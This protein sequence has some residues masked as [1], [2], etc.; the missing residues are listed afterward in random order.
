[1][2]LN[3]AQLVVERARLRPASPAIIT[4]NQVIT[5]GRLGVSIGV[6]ASHLREQGVTPGQ[7]VGISMGQNPLHVI[8]LL[9]LA[10]I[11]AVSLPLHIA[12]PQNRRALAAQRFGATSVVSGRDDMALAGLQFI[13]LAKLSFDGSSIP[14][15][16]EIY[17]VNPDTPFRIAI[18]S[19]TSGDPKGMLI[20]HGVMV[21]R[22]RRPEPGFTL[23]SRSIPMDLN[24]I[25]GFRPAMSALAMGA[26]VVLPRLMNPEQ[27]LHAVVSH[28]VT[29]ISLSPAQA[30]ELAEQFAIKGIHCPGLVCLRIVGG[31]LAPQQLEVLRRTVSPNVYV[32]YGSTESGVV[33]FAAPD[34]LERQPTSVGQVLDWAQIE[35]VDREGH[36]LPTGEAG[37]LRIRSEDQVSGYYNDA[38]RNHKHFRDGWFYSGDLGRFDEE[39]LLYIEGRVDEQLNVGGFKVNPDD[40]DAVLVAHPNVAEAGSFVLVREEGAELLAAAVVLRDGNS[41]D[42]IRS[43]A[44]TQLGPLAPTAYFIAKSLPRTITGKLR[45]GELSA[46]FASHEHLH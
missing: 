39:G 13:S 36:P 16:S 22:N 45:R 26:S 44:R 9:A 29:H 37:L 15:D 17:Q 43:H 18:S 31:P 10:Q 12:V 38:E 34:V 25:A 41:I 35:V 11:G 5:Y 1:M 8:T 32:T 42:D 33:A 6:V 28:N 4:H 46:Q 3:V 24:F 7:V 40:I 27:L 20:T 2:S 19:G 14:P 23:Q 21:S 30:H